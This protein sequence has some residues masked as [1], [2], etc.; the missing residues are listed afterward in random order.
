MSKR[1]IIGVDT[2]SEDHTVITILRHR[3]FD[4]FHHLLRRFKLYNKPPY[5]VVDTYDANPKTADREGG[6]T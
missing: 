6:Q 1:Y 3:S 4:W 2:G 5:E